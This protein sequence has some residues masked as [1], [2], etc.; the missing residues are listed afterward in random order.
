M[1]KITH[2]YMVCDHKKLEATL[3]LLIRELFKPEGLNEGG[4]FFV[5]TLERGASGI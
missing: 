5:V 1:Y 4:I 2:Y 3:V